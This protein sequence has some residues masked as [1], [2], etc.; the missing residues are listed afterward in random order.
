MSKNS[1]SGPLPTRAFTLMINGIAALMW[2]KTGNDENGN[3]VE[4]KDQSSDLMRHR[5]DGSW[6]LIIDNPYTYS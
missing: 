6:L 5:P 1:N 4:F 2:I 3:R